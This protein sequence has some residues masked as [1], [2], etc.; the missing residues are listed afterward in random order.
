DG[1]RTVLPSHM[2]PPFGLVLHELATNAA[3]HGALSTLDGR[4]DVHW[5]PADDGAVNVRWIEHGGPPVVE[6][7][8][9]GLGL[10]LVRGLIEHEIDG[11]VRMRFEPDGFVCEMRLPHRAAREATA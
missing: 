4:V 10:R 11:D 1:E 3:K 6:P 8:G 2:V 7:T 9:H 5:A